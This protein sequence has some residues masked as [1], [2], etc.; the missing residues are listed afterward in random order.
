MYI[1][2]SV[3]STFTKRHS[4]KGLTY[5]KVFAGR[6]ATRMYGNARSALLAALKSVSSRLADQRVW[7]PAFLCQSATDPVHLCGLQALYYDIDEHLRPKLTGNAIEPGDFIMIVHY[8]GLAQPL[9]KLRTLCTKNRSMLIE[10]CAHAL[11]D[12]ISNVRVGSYGDIAVF[13]LRKQLPVP[14][15]GILLVNGSMV[16][17]PLELDVVGKRRVSI[18]KM[19]L[20]G[21]ERIAFEREWNILPLKCWARSVVRK[22]A[23]SPVLASSIFLAEPSSLTLHILSDIDWQTSIDRKK[24]NYIMLSDRLAKVKSLILPVPLLPEGSVPQALP[25]WVSEPTSVCKKLRRMGIEAFQWPGNDQISCLNLSDY[26]GTE[27]WLKKNL[28]LPISEKL[29]PVHV[30]WMSNHVKAAVD[31]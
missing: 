17:H 10:D 19:I 23:S 6:I 1:P 31:S 7:L 29:G 25:I 27:M 13:S 18:A 22:F 28:C 8:F 30:E 4:E 11:P 3:V 24:E 16:S 26:P 20:M 5:E 12:P 14:D 2:G 21:V 15:G 9:E